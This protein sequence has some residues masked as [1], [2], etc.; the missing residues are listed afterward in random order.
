MDLQ[1]V[2]EGK[3]I[4]RRFVRPIGFFLLLLFKHKIHNL[5]RFFPDCRFEN[6]VAGKQILENSSIIFSIK[7]YRKVQK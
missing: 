6:F 7:A 1:T 5:V 4:E 3:Y 2:E